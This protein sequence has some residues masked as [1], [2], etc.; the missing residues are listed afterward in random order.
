VLVSAQANGLPKANLER[1]RNQLIGLAQVVAIPENADT[2]EIEAKIG[3]RYSAFGGAINIIFPYQKTDSGGFCATTR[4]L[5]GQLENIEAS[6]TRIEAEVLSIV[7]H[8]TNVPN[9]WKHISSEL[10]K[11]EILRSNLRKA[12][13]AVRVGGD[14]SIYES[15]LN[16]AAESL[17]SKDKA[18]QELHE[19]LEL[20]NA[21]LGQKIAESESL[22]FA[23]SSASSTV[24]LDTDA[25]ADSIAPLRNLFLVALNGE[26][27]LEEALLLA[28]K[29][30]PE[31]LVVLESAFASAR[32]SDRG[33]FLH[34]G[35]ALD[36]AGR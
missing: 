13:E 29:L 26:P 12:A 1:L 2:F 4:L 11:Q 16:E 7:S 23:L 20:S 3:R 34:G 10:V 35:K 6:G 33:G 36:L 17:S 14:V 30:F 21:N 15:L 25:L 19:A 28:T 18:I 27:S 9:S 22:K 24:G 31:R 5:L 32:E 8:R